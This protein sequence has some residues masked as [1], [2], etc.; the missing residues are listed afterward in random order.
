V[1]Q[2]SATLSRARLVAHIHYHL[3]YRR[4]LTPIQYDAMICVL[5]GRYITLLPGKLE[6]H[7]RQIA[8]DDWVI[9]WRVELFGFNSTA[10]FQC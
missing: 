10:L 6:V 1:D 8:L 4:L 7:P 2:L 9:D 5:F 3:G